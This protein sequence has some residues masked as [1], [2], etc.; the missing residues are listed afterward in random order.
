MTQLL[1]NYAVLLLSCP[2]RKGIVASVSRFIYEHNGNI[3]HAEQY[4]DTEKGR[5]FMRIEWELEG[6]KLKREQISS[7]F[8]PLA[9][10]FQMEWSLHFTD[11]IPNVAIFVSKT[12]HCLYELLL[13]QQSGE[14]GANIRL[15]ISNHPDLKPVAETFGVPY[16]VFPVTPENKEKVEQEELLLLKEHKIDLI[17]LARYMQI[18]TPAFVAHYPNRIINIH[19]SFLPAFAG[20]HPYHQARERGVKVIGATSHYVT[21]ELDAGPIIE[22]D[23]IRVSHRDRIAD[24]IRKGRDIEKLVLARAVKLHLENRIIVY[25]NRTIVFDT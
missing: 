22:Q 17:V 5:F 14:I 2:D 13:R 9:Q 15:I 20:P 25:E 19:H 8:S 7:F 3:V 24:L 11:Y 23:V 10:R 4:T 1:K 18:L 6:F 12:S 21:A 16:Y